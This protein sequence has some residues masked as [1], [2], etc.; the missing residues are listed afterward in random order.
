MAIR[1]A[2]GIVVLTVQAVVGADYYMQTRDAGLQWG[3]LSAADYQRIIQLRF[4]KSRG[5]G[6]QLALSEF[7]TPAQSL[8]R[9]EDATEAEETKICVRRGTTRHCQ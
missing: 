4:A 8:D 5:G 6:E 7:S 3:E 1:K 2:V 9:A